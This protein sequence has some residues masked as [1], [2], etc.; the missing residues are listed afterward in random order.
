MTSQSKFSHQILSCFPGAG[1]CEVV[2]MV[3]EELIFGSNMRGSAEYRQAICKVL[4]KRAIMEVAA[5][6]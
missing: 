5:C 4:V 6:K 2:E 3:T 1:P